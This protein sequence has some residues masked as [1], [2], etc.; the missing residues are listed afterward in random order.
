MLDEAMQK[1]AMHITA[2]RRREIIN[3]IVDANPDLPRADAERA[4]LT[5]L[6]MLVQPVPKRRV[7]KVDAPARLERICELLRTTDY[8]LAQIASIVGLSLT[9]VS[10]LLAQARADGMDIPERTSGLRTINLQARAKV[11]EMAKSGAILSEMAVAIGANG[12]SA[13]Q[14]LLNSLR[15]A[16]ETVPHMGEVERWR[17]KLH[18]IRQEMNEV[19]YQIKSMGGHPVT[20]EYYASRLAAIKAR[21]DDVAAAK[22]EGVLTMPPNA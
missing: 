2:Q 9:R 4:V 8:P 10:Q 14:T 19:E 12:V 16:G 11:L 7:K 6:S 15:R 13:V 17:F 18:E 20:R 22:P 1:A 21:Y 5:T 3:A